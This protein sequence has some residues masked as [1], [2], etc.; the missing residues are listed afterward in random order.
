M[1]MK[2]WGRRLAGTV[3]LLAATAC[4]GSTLHSHQASLPAYE[5]D[6]TEV[7]VAQ[8]R[9]CVDAHACDTD[10]L[11]ES[12][13]GSKALCNWQRPGKDDHPINCIEWRQADAYCRWAGKRLP[14]GVEWEAGARG[15]SGNQYPWGNDAPERGGA[16]FAGWRV[17]TR[18]QLARTHSGRPLLAFRTWLATFGSGPQAR[19]MRVARTESCEAASQGALSRHPTCV[20]HSSKS[21]VRRPTT[22]GS[23]F[24]APVDH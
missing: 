13:H 16:R 4:G 1:R 3:T 6:V 9:A 12:E 7:T 17:K 15:P 14:T 24:A 22:M 11:N 18:A 19:M 10:R 21:T 8:Y 20:P 5:L 23:A 2:P